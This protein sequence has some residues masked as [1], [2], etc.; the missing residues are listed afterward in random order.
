[1]TETQATRVLAVL[2]AAP[3]QYVKQRVI[4]QAVTQAGSHLPM[5]RHA[6]SLVLNRLMREGLVTLRRDPDDPAFEYEWKA[7]D[8]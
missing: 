3:G 2:R 5:P 1:M 6:S 7:C 4:E 8:V